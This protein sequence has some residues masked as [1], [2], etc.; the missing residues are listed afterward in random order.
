[1]EKRGSSEI[2]RGALSLL[3]GLFYGAVV[4]TLPLWTTPNVHFRNRLTDRTLTT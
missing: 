3:E 1:M 4:H 2:K